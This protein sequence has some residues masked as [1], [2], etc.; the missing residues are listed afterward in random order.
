LRLVKNQFILFSTTLILSGCIGTKYL[1]EDEKLLYKQNIK[2]EKP[3]NKNDLEQLYAQVPN[4]RFPIIP[5][6]TYV[7]LYYWGQKNY[8]IPK[9]EEQK[10][11]T[12]TKF[13]NKIEKAAT[14]KGKV[15]RIEKRKKKKI[16]KIDKNI[17]EGNF[18]MRIGEPITIYD[19]AQ[20]KVTLNRFDLYLDSKGY[21]NSTIDHKIHGNGNRITSNYIIKSGPAY[22][23]DTLFLETGDSSIT[24]LINKTNQES[25]LKVGKNYEQSNLTKERERLDLLMKDNGYYDFSRQYIE[26]AVDTSYLQPLHVAVKTLVNKPVKWDYHKI[27]HVDSINFFSDVSDKTI[28]DSLMQTEAYKG[29][30]YRFQKNRYSKKVL[31]RRIFIKKDSLY[32]KTKTYSTQRQLAN[33]DMFR[34]INIKYDSVDGQLIANIFTSPLSR[35][36]WTNEIGVNVTQGY[37]GPFYNVTFKKRNIFRGLEIFEISSRLG[38]EGVASVNNANEIYTSIEAGVNASLT[39]PQFVLPISN[40]IK[41]RLGQVNPKTR[42]LAGYTYTRRPEYI[43][44]NT[45]FSNTYSWQNARTTFYQVTLTDIS[46][47]ESEITDSTFQVRLVQLENNG[48]R[49]INAF[50]PSLVTSMNGSATWNFNGYGLNFSNSSFL[51]LYLE[52]GGTS[53]NFVNTDFLEREA[54]EFYKFYKLN[55]DYRKIHP[56]NKNTTIAYRVNVG[57]A[58][59]YSK[60]A[61]LPYEKYFFAGGSN[62]I[63]AWRP[64]RLGPGS[65]APIDTLTNLVSYDF[66]QPGEILF[67]GSLELRK[68]LVGF[69]DYAFFVD[70]GN[71]WT[72]K[73]EESRPGSQFQSNRFFKEIAVGA[74]LGL[75]FDFSFLILRLDAGFKIYDPARPEQKRFILTKGFYD[76]PF[77]AKDSEVVIYNIGIGYPF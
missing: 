15:S 3:I 37:P 75:R 2:V 64:R 14:K 5:F 55:L 60:N 13:D 33:L 6:S 27:Y 47:I 1:K 31:N 32:S 35:Y 72:I 57:F 21:F 68:N 9:Y 12:Q 25:Q 29:I 70:F 30:T 22:K 8:D 4:R 59:P 46:L 19:T 50:K 76:A 61:I 28:P 52:S 45:N 43:R 63:R 71:T 36:Q 65:Y 51:R 77:T 24:K 38:A 7:W 16:E 10:A 56:I 66:E 73:E 41:Q 40:S 74:G 42:L 62:G 58:K 20:T 23:I 67:E 44:K 53:L 69:I 39:F 34:F 17:T 48:N 11:H 18:L 49:L 54:L 26:F